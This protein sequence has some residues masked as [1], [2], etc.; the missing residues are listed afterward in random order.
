MLRRVEV[1]AVLLAAAAATA[2]AQEQDPPSRVARI[3]YLSGSVSF[4]PDN[5]DDW[6]AATLN[7]PLTL[8]DHL[9]TDDDAW[10]EMHIGSTAIRMAPRTA[11][12]VLN[13][14]DR[15]VQL[16]LT[17]GALN[18]RL[19]SLAEDEVFEIDTPNAAVILRQ[20]GV[21]RVDA[22]GD[23]NSTVAT[24][25]GGDAEISAATSAFSVYASES[26][27]ITGMDTISQEVGAAAPPDLFDNWCEERDARERDIQ[28]TRYVSPQMTGYEDLDSYGVWREQAEYGWVWAPRVDAGWAPYRYGHWAW[29]DPWGW[30][31]IDDAPWGFAPFH[32]G[33][34][35][36]IGGTWVWVPGTRV[37]RPVYAPALVVFIGGPRIAVSVGLA[38]DVV[39]WFP[40]GPHEIYRPAYRASEVYVRQ[41]NVTHVSSV[42]VIDAR[43]VNQRLP[44][45]VTAVRHETFV[46]ARQVA[47]GAVRLDARELADTQVLGTTAPLQPGRESRLAGAPVSNRPPARYASRPVVARTPPPSRMRPMVRT[48][49]PAPGSM[50]PQGGRIRSEAPVMAPQP[51]APPPVRN[52][53]RPVFQRPVQPPAPERRAEEPRRPEPRRVEKP[54]TLAPLPRTEEPRRTEPPRRIESPRVERPQPAQRAPAAQAPPPPPPERPAAEQRHEGRE[55]VRGRGGERKAD[56]KEEK[57]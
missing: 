27:T 57:K 34:W 3:N 39:A 25:R 2:L 51:E 45:A 49:T 5:L 13:L 1:L 7:Y 46:S 50:R 56:K 52:D 47:R 9:W 8:G 16:S 28:S 36:V 32:Y 54:R 10:A 4:R 44:G 48:I 33:R 53:R 6:A 55:Q 23:R 42:N 19:D 18:V 17:Q 35:A 43:Y 12:S 21:Y 40:L 31:W 20:P 29:I 11:L 38:G 15:T 30:T 24:V 26:G 14:D 37:M 22:D 41:V